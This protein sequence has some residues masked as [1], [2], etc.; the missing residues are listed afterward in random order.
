MTTSIPGSPPVSAYI[1]C[2]NNAATIRLAVEGIQKQ[3]HPVEELFV[4]DDGSSD[5]SAGIVE[6]LGV[7]VIRLGTNQGRGAVRAR[8]METARHEFVLCCDATNRLAPDFLEGALKWFSNENVL[9]VFGRWYDPNT[10]N[11]VDRWRARHLFQQELVHEVKHHCDLATYGAVVRK[12]VIMRLGSYN[13]LL[14]HGEDWDLGIRMMRVGDTV[15]DPALEIEPVARN[16][17]FQVMERY[18]RWNRAGIRKYGLREFIDSHVVSWKILMPRDLEKR[19]WPAALITAM[20]PYFSLA[21]ADKKMA[22]PDAPATSPKSTN[23]SDQ[24]VNP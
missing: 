5:N 1:P 4:V 7:R 23:T 11:V 10:R 15:F 16:T 22:N 3:T 19:D 8:A 20:L 9:G 12:S 18:C 6:S 2:F 21:L 17:F 13:P 24:A 14:R